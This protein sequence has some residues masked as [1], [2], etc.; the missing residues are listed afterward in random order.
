MDALAHRIKSAPHAATDVPTQRLSAVPTA[1]PLT[2]QEGHTVRRTVE[3]QA[4]G[5]SALPT[6]PQIVVPSPPVAL[7]DG[8]PH[9]QRGQLPPNRWPKNPLRLTAARAAYLAHYKRLLKTQSDRTSIDNERLLESFADFL[10]SQHSELGE[11]PWVHDLDSSHVIQFL[12]EHAERA[13]KRKNADGMAL[14]AAPRTMLKKL[15]G[16]CHFFDH[17]YRT[18][19]STKE[20]IR[21]CAALKCPPVRRSENGCVGRSDNA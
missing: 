11:D 4:I 15:H 16:L 19:K 6:A 20:R 13:G 2:P 5:I 17:Q 9:R 14:S 1:G 7:D 21:R 3:P 8:P 18:A 12:S 10:S